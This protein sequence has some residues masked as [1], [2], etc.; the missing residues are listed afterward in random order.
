MGLQRGIKI[1]HISKVL[2]FDALV[3]DVTPGPLIL[4]YFGVQKSIK[5]VKEF[6]YMYLI[7]N[8]FEKSIL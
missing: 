5:V 7:L 4:R 8:I 2:A 3:S 1:L 6:L